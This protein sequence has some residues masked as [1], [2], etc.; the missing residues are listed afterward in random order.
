ME[1]HGK[2]P[3]KEEVHAME[4]EDAWEYVCKLLDNAADMREEKKKAEEQETKEKEEKKKYQA[5][6]TKEIIK[7]NRVPYSGKEGRIG[8][9]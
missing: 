3:T 6:R 4:A 2:L 9:D 8:R 5:E 7:E 1:D